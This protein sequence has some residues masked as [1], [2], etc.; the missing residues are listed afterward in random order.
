MCPLHVDHD[1]RNLD[2]LERNGVR[3]EGLGRTH[4]VRR[5]KHP[6]IVIPALR[7]GFKNNGLIEIASESDDGSETEEEEAPDGTIYKLSTEGIKLDFI[8]KVK[9]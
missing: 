4:R 8:D 7:R 3:Y 2:P 1:L 5:P 9:R 6:S